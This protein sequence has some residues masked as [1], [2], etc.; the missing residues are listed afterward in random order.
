[1]KTTREHYK[2]VE[3]WWKY[4]IVLKWYVK[5]IG[6]DGSRV[7]LKLGKITRSMMLHLYLELYSQCK[8]GISHFWTENLR[9]A[10]KNTMFTWIL[11]S[12]DET[13]LSVWKFVSLL[14]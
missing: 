5:T 1:M 7:M 13:N 8:I 12:K 10:Q 2:F 9:F 3:K 4:W 14:N 11:G 6:Y